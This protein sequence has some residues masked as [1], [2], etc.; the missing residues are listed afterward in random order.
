MQDKQDTQSTSSGHARGDTQDIQDT[1]ERMDSG[2]A[3]SMAVD[4][5]RGPHKV[6]EGLALELVEV[7]PSISDELI[8]RM[9]CII[10]FFIW[11]HARG[12][13]RII[14]S[15]LSLPP[16]TGTPSVQSRKT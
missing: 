7:L 1:L 10:Q 6:N 11:F 4:I 15:L 16:A 2:P 13:P 3:V 8:L 12:P 14:P 9:Y 5:L